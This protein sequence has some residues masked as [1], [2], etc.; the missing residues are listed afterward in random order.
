MPILLPTVNNE[1]RQR[2]QRPQF[3][4]PSH[5]SFIP[6]HQFGQK[7]KIF[8]L[9]FPWNGFPHTPE[10]YVAQTGDARGLLNRSGEK[11][12]VFASHSRMMRVGP[13]CPVEPS[14]LF[15]DI[16]PQPHHGLWESFTGRWLHLANWTCCGSTRASG[17][18]INQTS[19]DFLSFAWSHHVQQ[20]PWF[21]LFNLRKTEC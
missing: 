21:F 10:I 5:A 1:R 6:N 19:A 2:K 13:L 20:L 17:Y 3:R 11:T 4:I 16:W 12:T 7:S 15:R 18:H 9:R 8:L 14:G